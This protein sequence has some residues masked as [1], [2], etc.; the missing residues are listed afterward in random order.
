LLNFKVTDVVGDLKIESKVGQL[1]W[2]SV[3]DVFNIPAA[4]KM[5]GFDERLSAYVS[6]QVILQEFIEDLTE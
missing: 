5:R 4:Q 1:Q 6:N 2:L 3:V